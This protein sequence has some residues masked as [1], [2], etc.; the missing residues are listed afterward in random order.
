MGNYNKERIYNCDDPYPGFLSPANIL[1]AACKTVFYLIVVL[2]LFNMLWII[3]L[4][5]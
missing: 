5:F 1:E 2:N 3:M 4:A